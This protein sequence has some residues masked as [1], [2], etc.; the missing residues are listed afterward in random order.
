MTAFRLR[1]HERPSVEYHNERR[2]LACSP[3]GLMRLQGTLLALAAMAVGGD[4]ASAPS[5]SC[6]CGTLHLTAS[7]DGNGCHLRNVWAKD[8][9]GG[10]GTAK[11]S[12]ELPRQCGTVSC[13][14]SPEG[15]LTGT[16]AFTTLL[17]EAPSTVPGKG[18][19]GAAPADIRAP[20]A[21]R[22]CSQEEDLRRAY[23]AFTA[24]NQYNFGE[25]NT[26]AY[27]YRGPQPTR[28]KF[29]L[30]RM[31]DGCVQI[32]RPSFREQVRGLDIL[33]SVTIM[34]PTSPPPSA[35]LHSPTFIPRQN[36]S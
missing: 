27:L 22:F 34:S 7:R 19:K 26:Q 36:A 24:R 11:L 32:T 25:F 8:E 9:I 33:P 15:E 21:P 14:P 1:G 23:V 4:D 35:Y 31:K 2:G 29:A 18:G 16:C 28:R 20:Y 6:S 3:A 12:G 30:V 13:P 10:E 5:P 17:M